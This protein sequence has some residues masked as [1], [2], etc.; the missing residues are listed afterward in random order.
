[1]IPDRDARDATAE[2]DGW[3]RPRHDRSFRIEH[4]EFDAARLD[5]YDYDVGATRL[6]QAWA[7]DE[8]HLARTLTEW[9]VVRAP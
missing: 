7:A 8:H 3:V 2:R 4:W 6:R 5:G 9:G 1:V